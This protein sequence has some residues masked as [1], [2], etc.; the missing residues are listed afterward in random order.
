MAANRLTT[1]RPGPTPL[2]SAA[3]TV[4][5]DRG[6][7]AIIPAKDE[8]ARIAATATAA[9]A[10]PGVDLVVVVDDGSTDRT[11]A[12]AR[13]AGAWVV[14]HHRNRGKAAA[15]KTGGR[16]VHEHGAGRLLLFLDADL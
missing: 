15:M 8:E 11:A 6:V 1:P 9:A 14:R 16:A 5:A 3:M 2:G 10:I 13:E 7:A 4:R 12:V